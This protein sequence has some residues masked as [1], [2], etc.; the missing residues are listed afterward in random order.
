MWDIYEGSQTWL[1]ETVGSKALHAAQ[2]WTVG[3]AQL[4]IPKLVNHPG[5]HAVKAEETGL[6]VSW[7]SCTSSNGVSTD[8]TP[9]HTQAALLAFMTYY[10]YMND[11]CFPQTYAVS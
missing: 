9:Y 7:F 3:M 1:G 11:L 2:R 10:S 8:S 5:T 4:L 6:N